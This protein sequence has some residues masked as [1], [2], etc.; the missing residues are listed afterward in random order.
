[1]EFDLG[2]GYSDPLGDSLSD[3]GKINLWVF[4]T[5]DE[6]M[7]LGLVEV[8]GDSPLADREQRRLYR[9][10]RDSGYKPGVAEVSACLRKYMIELATPEFLGLFQTVIANGIA[11]L[12][13]KVADERQEE[14]RQAEIKRA[15][16]YPDGWIPL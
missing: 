12:K 3:E 10:L 1:M 2:H 13:Q 14:A 11:A 15:Y 8:A 7:T 16:G 6:F 5:M 4:G 9:E